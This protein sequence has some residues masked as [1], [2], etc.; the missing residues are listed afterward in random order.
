VRVGPRDAFLLP[1]SRQTTLDWNPG[2]L[3]T[4]TARPF[5]RV[6]DRL[7]LAGS[8]SWFRRGT[9]T[10]SSDA[11]D[12]PAASDLSAMALGSDASAL[13]VGVALAY[14]H[15]GRHVDGATRMPVEAGLALE[16]TI[17]SGS[18]LVSQQTVTR[19]WFRVYKRLF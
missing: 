14:A 15:D 1:A 6:A 8:A 2:D 7:S 16:R 13:K 4:I 3:L 10:W 17:W 18:G 12:A 11:A 9:D 19:M 5:V